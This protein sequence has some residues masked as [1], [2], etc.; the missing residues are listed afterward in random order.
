MQ[1]PRVDVDESYINTAQR[2]YGHS[3]QFVCER[4][5]H[6]NVTELGAFDT[7]PALG[8]IQISTTM[9]RATSSVLVTLR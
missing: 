2:R 5:S 9:R 3:A 7:L 4:V 1:L 6:H 8:L